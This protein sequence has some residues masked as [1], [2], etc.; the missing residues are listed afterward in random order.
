MSGIK[1][2]AHHPGDII[3]D[4]R[5]PLRRAQPLRRQNQPNEGLRGERHAPPDSTTRVEPKNR[6]RLNGVRCA[7]S[8]KARGSL[9]FLSLGL[10]TY[11]CRGVY[12]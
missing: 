12:S 3:L 5:D 11:S 1:I 7:R 6:V 2:A 4:S 8:T 10:L 9:T